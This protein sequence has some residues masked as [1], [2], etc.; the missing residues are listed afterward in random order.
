MIAGWC[1]GRHIHYQSDGEP[2]LELSRVR[3]GQLGRLVSRPE[4]CELRVHALCVSHV[5]VP[6]DEDEDDEDDQD[7]NENENKNG[8]GRE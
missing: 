1:R 8:S 7:G 2:L 6:L 5:F 3:H 4:V